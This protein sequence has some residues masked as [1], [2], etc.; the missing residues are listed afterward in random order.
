MAV[1]VQRFLNGMPSDH[2]IFIGRNN[3]R[4]D[5]AVTARDARSAGPIRI[6]IE[7]DTQPRSILLDLLPNRSSVFAD[8]AGKHQSIQL[9][10]RGS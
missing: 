2:E 4:G 1:V 8:A 10:Q 7:H 6:D 9:T 3:P 5:A